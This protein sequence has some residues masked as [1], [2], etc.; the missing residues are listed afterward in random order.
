[1][2]THADP[3]PKAQFSSSAPISQSKSGGSDKE[4]YVVSIH[5]LSSIATIVSWPFVLTPHMPGTGTSE[6]ALLAVVVQVYQ[7]LFIKEYVIESI[8][9]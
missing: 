9:F 8:P 7:L 2:Y 3:F 5:P 4:T 1:M 6:V